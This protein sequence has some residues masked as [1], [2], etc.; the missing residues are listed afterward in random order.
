MADTDEKAENTPHINKDR[1]SFP[2]WN[3]APEV[4][5]NICNP[6]VTDKIRN[7]GTEGNHYPPKI[8][9]VISRAV[10]KRKTDKGKPI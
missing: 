3:K 5:N 4:F 9:S 1:V 2:A 8:I 10:K 6:T 7:T